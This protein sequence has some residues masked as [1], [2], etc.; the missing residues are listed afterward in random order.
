MRSSA[1]THRLFPR[2]KRSE[3]EAL[4]RSSSH[5]HAYETGYCSQHIFSP[6]VLLHRADVLGFRIL[7]GGC[8]WQRAGRDTEK[9]RERET[10]SRTTERRGDSWSGWNI[11]VSVFLAD[12]GKALWNGGN[13]MARRLRTIGVHRTGCSKIPFSA[14]TANEEARRYGPHFV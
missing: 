13:S 8:T 10:F 1:L 3:G 7:A 11:R 14:A 4:T 5:P 9:V 12:C 2:T 6:S